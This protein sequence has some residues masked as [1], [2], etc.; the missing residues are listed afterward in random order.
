MN[1]KIM[2]MGLSAL[3]MSTSAM[4]SAK[5]LYFVINEGPTQKVFNLNM[6]PLYSPILSKNVQ[7]ACEYKSANGVI[8][9]FGFESSVCGGGPVMAL[10]LSGKSPDGKEFGA[11]VMTLYVEHRSVVL[12]ASIGAG[13]NSGI[14]FTVMSATQYQVALKQNAFEGELKLPQID[15]VPSVSRDDAL[16]D[17]AL[18]AG[19]MN[20]RLERKQYFCNHR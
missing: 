12:S 7:L 8:Q 6:D 17:E 1:T 15:Q 14:D 16:R 3:L 13:N 5:Y 19:A 20:C 2:L 9:R 4:A 18:P 10:G 11:D